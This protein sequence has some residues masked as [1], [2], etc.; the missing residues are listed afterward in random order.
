M[1]GSELRAIF[2]G[3]WDGGGTE[4]HG[5]V[6]HEGRILKIE[7]LR[8]SNW[9]CSVFCDGQCVASARASAASEAVQTAFEML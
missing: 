4:I 5:L 7:L 1:T 6:E 3:T 8:T 9:T 2:G